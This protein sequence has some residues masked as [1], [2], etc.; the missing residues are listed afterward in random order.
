MM[1]WPGLNG[2]GRRGQWEVTLEDRMAI[3]AIL[4]FIGQRIICLLFFHPLFLLHQC[5]LDAILQNSIW[6]HKR[7]RS[8]QLTSSSIRSCWKQCTFKN[9]QINYFNLKFSSLNSHVRPRN[10]STLAALLLGHT[11][12]SPGSVRTRRLMLRRKHLEDV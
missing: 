9:S 4:F 8:Q 12:K 10:I 2:T 7:E 5:P 3:S 6:Q 1:T 11:E